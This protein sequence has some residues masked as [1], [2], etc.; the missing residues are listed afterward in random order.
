MISRGIGHVVF[1]CE[2]MPQPASMPSVP[3][4]FC[5]DW[6]PVLE[7]WLDLQTNYELYP[8]SIILLLLADTLLARR[9]G[10]YLKP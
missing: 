4:M 7:G 3:V 6:P 5:V 10:N 2:M 8:E 9:Q 1:Q